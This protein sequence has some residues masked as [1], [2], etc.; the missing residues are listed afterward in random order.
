MKILTIGDSWI[1]CQWPVIMG[2]TAPFRQGVRGSTAHQWATDY[3]SM[4]S[5]AIA[6]EASSVIISLLGNDAISAA[7]DGNVTL[8]EIID[9]VSNLAKVVNAIKREQTIVLLYADPFC[10]KDPRATIGVKMINSAIKLACGGLDVDFADTGDCLTSD[11]FDGKDIHPNKD[12][13]VAI[14]A[15]MTK[16]LQIEAG[17]V[18]L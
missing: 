18:A 15:M 3:N 13:Q 12:G 9:G 2:V 16:I 7:S 4:L 8:K 17:K 6:T 11:H 10:G 5:K 14:A 1:D